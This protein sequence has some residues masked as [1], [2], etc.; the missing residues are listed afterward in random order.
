ML[1]DT[2]QTDD[3][4]IIIPKLAHDGSNWVIYWDC[5]LWSFRTNSTDS[6][7][8]HD[9]PPAPYVA[10]GQVNGLDVNVC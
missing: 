3:T 4:K 10:I 2:M 7:F 5:M 9:S 8:M 1:L 6:H